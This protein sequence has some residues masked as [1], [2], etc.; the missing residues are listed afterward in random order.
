MADL[1]ILG[2]IPKR[3]YSSD[4][5]KSTSISP[6]KRE[7]YG[8]VEKHSKGSDPIASSDHNTYTHCESPPKSLLEMKKLK[9]SK[10]SPPKDAP[11]KME[12]NSWDTK[13]PSIPVSSNNDTEKTISKM[14]LSQDYY[15]GG[16]IAEKVKLSRRKAAMKKEEVKPQEVAIKKPIQ[17]KKRKA[18]T[19][20]QK[21][22]SSP[23]KNSE[24]AAVAKG[25]E[26]KK[27]LRISLKMN[28]ATR[29]RLLNNAKAAREKA[30]KASRKAKRPP[31]VVQIKRK[32]KKRWI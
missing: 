17:K 9:K 28:L 8:G 25:D 29:I 31:T 1:N 26:K 12:N 13:K 3:K 2:R 14:F 4:R 24:N 23:S 18:K 10:Y 19:T 6:M 30:A 7:T 27:P 21:A 20:K 5:T 11:M 32:K 16:N 15:G 22:L